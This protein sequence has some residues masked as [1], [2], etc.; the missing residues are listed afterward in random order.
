MFHKCTVS[1]E[2]S[3]NHPLK[4]TST[5]RDPRERERERE[6]AVLYMTAA[7]LLWSIGRMLCNKCGRLGLDFRS[8]RTR[9]LVY[10]WCKISPY[11]AFSSLGSIEELGTQ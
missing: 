5:E 10:E 1:E 6:N 11:L 7:R 2:G 3:G 9:D 4:S 8:I